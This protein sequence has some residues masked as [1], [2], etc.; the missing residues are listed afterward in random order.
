MAGGHSISEDSVP[1]EIEEDGFALTNVL[2]P[3]WQ[4]GPVPMN[5]SV[6]NADLM[7]DGTFSGNAH[8]VFLEDRSVLSRTFIAMEMLDYYPVDAAGKHALVHHGHDD[9]SHRKMNAEMEGHINPQEQQS[10]EASY[11]S[12]VLSPVYWGHGKGLVGFVMLVLGWE[13]FM[14]SLSSA[15]TAGLDVVLSDSCGTLITYG[16]ASSGFEFKGEGDLHDQNY[17]SMVK[18][19]QAS[20]DFSD[21]AE[22][23]HETCSYLLSVY[24]TKS[25]EEEYENQSPVFLAIVIVLIFIF[26]ALVFT[27]YDWAVVRRQIRVTLV[28]KKTQAI[29][30]NMFPKNVQ[31]RLLDKLEDD[32]HAKEKKYFRA[33]DHIQRFVEDGGGM[34]AQG[35]RMADFSVPIADLF[36]EATIL[37]ADIVGF[38]A[39]SSTREPAQVFELLESVYSV[40][41]RIAKR[42]KIFKVETVGDCYVAVAGLPEPR[43][44]HSVAMARFSCECLSAFIDVSKKLVVELGP[45]TEELGL[46]LGLHSGPV[47]A[48]VLRGERARFQ[49]FGDTVNTA[50]RMESTGYR[51]RIQVSEETANALKAHGKAD[52]LKA[53]T[54]TV[55]A[56]GKGELQTMWVACDDKTRQLGMFDEIDGISGHVKTKV[57]QTSVADR[58]GRLIAWNCD[59]LSKIMKQI[60]ARREALEVQPDTPEQ[61]KRIETELKLSRYVLGEVQEVVRLPHYKQADHFFDPDSVELG[62]T[63]ENQLHRFVQTLAA[64]YQDNPFHNFEHASHVTMSVT[65][66]L[67]RI[68][69]PDSH[70]VELNSEE[71]L[72]D[73]TY[74]ITS[75]P[76]TQFA[77]VFSAL[78][79]DADH[80]G[81]PNTRLMQENPALAAVYQNKSV[82][83]QNSVCLAW[84]LLMQDDFTELREVIYVT[85]AEFLRFRQLVVNIVLATDIMDKDLGALRK[86][87]WQKAFS[88]AALDNC[89]DDVHRKA[90]IVMEHLIQASDISHTMQHWHIYRKWNHRFFKEQY[91][92]FL[93]GRAET[94]PSENWY[95]GEKGFFDSY[96]IPLAKK[97]K[98]CGVFGVSSDEYLQ[99]ALQNREE[100]EHRGQEIVA[101]M[102]EEYMSNMNNSQKLQLDLVNLG[103]SSES[104]FDVDE[105]EFVEEVDHVVEESK[106]D[107][108][109]LATAVDD[110]AFSPRRRRATLSADM[111]MNDR[112]KLKPASSASFRSLNAPPFVSETTD[113]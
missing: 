41:D 57:P 69:A 2:G 106:R 60:I 99:Y 58:Y 62:V 98:D 111:K 14:S 53:R 88:E 66:L 72:H 104:G 109:V 21:D 79:H 76:T 24:P 26:A 65:K 45:E 81:V 110:V 94:D 77:L 10:V 47:T 36:P 1:F 30:S 27:V 18:T 67:S 12:Y 35:K 91:E 51:N 82:A 17:N 34:G 100:W 96:I 20:E 40:F 50:A 33:T 108:S 90:T 87:R 70:E 84:D 31:A 83:E 71:A 101:A 59:I 39:W 4:S 3:V 22:H 32:E 43:F 44:D 9:H 92:A 74:G 29:V 52:W 11:S 95:E 112:M 113:I 49:L 5:N 54:D 19:V 89:S 13:T 48:G 105:T 107:T 6:I 25:L 46:R 8:I 64:M 63:V 78:I 80:P 85:R 73:H 68:I 7:L 23:L 97:L 56:K 102:V 86:E 55:V 15:G 38:T 103:G 75:D 28:A 16:L 93:E 61:I 37:F 42:R